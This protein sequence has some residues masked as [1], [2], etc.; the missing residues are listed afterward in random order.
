MPGWAMAQSDAA[1]GGALAA[2]ATISR[3]HPAD[4]RD[5][6]R[7]RPTRAGPHR[8]GS[9]DEGVSGLGPGPTSL[10]GWPMALVGCSVA[11]NLVSDSLQSLPRGRQQARRAATAI[12]GTRARSEASEW[13]QV[14]M[15]CPCWA[16]QGGSLIV[17]GMTCCDQGAIAGAQVKPYPLISPV[18]TANPCPL[19]PARRPGG[20]GLLSIRTRRRRPAIVHK[21]RVSPGA[22]RSGD[23]TGGRGRVGQ[24]RR[25]AL[26]RRPGSR[27]GTPP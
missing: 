9:R 26:R 24:S 16:D 1:E 23:R 7:A 22:G 5:G 14:G 27:A 18:A 21:A 12:L 6:R 13:Q 25:P 20:A 19:P 10:P 15:P 2:H 3:P 11:T 4:A 8:F 17:Q